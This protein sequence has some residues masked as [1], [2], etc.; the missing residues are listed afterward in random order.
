MRATTTLIGIA[1]LVIGASTVAAER[2]AN[3]YAGQQAR[4]IKALSE[5]DV[6]ALRNG[7]GMGMAKAADSTAILG[8]ATSSRSRASFVSPTTKPAG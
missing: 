7:D 4:S 5:D 8:R 3:P 1:A 2:S 6:T